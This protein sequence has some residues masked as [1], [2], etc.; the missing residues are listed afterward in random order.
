MGHFVDKSLCFST[1]GILDTFSSERLG[2][3]NRS[4]SEYTMFTNTD[5]N[6]YTKTKCKHNTRVQ[7]D[8][9]KECEEEYRCD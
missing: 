3:M 4:F 6:I 5:K 8:E 2:D 9:N 1:L 7:N